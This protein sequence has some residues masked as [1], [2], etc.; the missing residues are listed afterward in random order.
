M[1]LLLRK[2]F[3]VL[4]FGLLAQFAWAAGNGQGQSGHLPV[5][6]GKGSLTVAGQGYW[7][8]E[9]YESGASPSISA[10]DNAGN[11]LP[12]GMYRYEFRSFPTSADASPR[13]QNLDRTEGKGISHGRGKAKGVNTVSGRFEVKGGEVLFR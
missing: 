11:V 5:V 10:Y 1:N 3:G 8:R 12:D 2:T 9:T 7:Y 13:Q 6:V 4:L